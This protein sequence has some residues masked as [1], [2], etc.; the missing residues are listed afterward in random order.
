MLAIAASK[1]AATPA[2]L[3]ECMAASTDIRM[4]FFG[5][6]RSAPTASKKR[7]SFAS[8]G[9]EACAAAPKS[10]HASGMGAQQ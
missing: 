2:L 9:L 5:V 4:A 7:S 3:Q 6:R 10:G 8:A 1:E